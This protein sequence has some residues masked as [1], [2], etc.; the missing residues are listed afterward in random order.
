MFRI[1]KLSLHNFKG[2]K[3][4]EISFDRPRTI[5]GGPNGYGK[6]SIFDALELLFTGSIK[7]ML[8]YKSG[9]D[10]RTTLKENYKPLVFDTS[11]DEITVE[12]IL[13][14]DDGNELRV[15]RWAE[16]SRM[17][18]PVDF[19][20]FS[21]LQYY[22]Q[23]TGT[24]EDVDT[25]VDLT[26]IFTPL[27]EQYNFLNYLTQEE[28]N[29]FL[30]C[31]ESERKQKINSLFNTTEF[32]VS[33]ERLLLVRNEVL[34]RA[35][36]LSDE[37]TKVEKDIEG[38]KSMA[39]QTNQGESDGTGHTK[40]F[41]KEIE[42]DELEPH[43]SFET[44]NNILG[45]NG[46]L[47]QL[48][49]YCQNAAIYELYETYNKLDTIQ[50]ADN[51]RRL[52]LWLEWRKKEELLTRFDKYENELRNKWEGLTLASIHLFSLDVPSY[53]PEGLINQ[54]DVENL[55]EQLSSIK[56]YA[57]S[58]GNLQKAYSDL[59][60]ARKI[61]ERTLLDVE[62]ELKLTKCPL[63]GT[64]HNSESELVK[65]ITDFGIQFNDSL[66][67]ITQGVATSVEQVKAQIEKIIIKPIDEFFRSSGISRELFDSYM[68][69]DRNSL[70]E[71]YSFLIRRL[72]ISG[73]SLEDEQLLV[74]HIKKWENENPLVLP[75]KLDV[76]LLR[77]VYS[78]YG[79]YLLP[80]MANGAAI[81]KKR[82]YLTNLWNETTSKYLAEKNSLVTAL[83]AQYAKLN[84]RASLIKQTMD[85]IKIQ[86]SS[87]LSRMVSQIETLFYIYTGRIMQ[88]NYYGRGCYLK[89]N[90]ANSNVLFTSGSPENEVDALFKMSSGQLVS[91]SVAF[92][93]TVN[94]LYANHH[95]IAIDDPVQTIDDL[96]LWGLMETLRHDFIDSTILLSTHERDFGLLL[97]DK[98]NKMGLPTEY[99]DMSQHHK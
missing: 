89:Y 33:V 59:A 34:T 3:E 37:I 51:M 4:T 29:C 93:L 24:F 30:K 74:T 64:E 38:L 95:I 7:R 66:N 94:K 79:R 16:Q 63:C 20:A 49:Y 73:D 52:V 77:R 91:I 80:E 68:A 90:S 97:T 87:Y 85:K 21:N 92:M 84:G 88:D 39:Y 18:N 96:N 12:A 10:S 69:L 70:G 26:G 54:E 60:G 11:I 23:T 1:V 81:E 32:D 56:I 62:D 35:R 9:H 99:V 67:Q 98:F 53:L 46:L 47:D 50:E 8:D 17:R 22:N 42:W 19:S 75:E 76:A 40:L 36:G 13:L 83:R 2:F 48:N 58:A 14:V 61:A 82:Q 15:R 65:R 25:N 55:N 78:S 57:T 72:S 45:E 44:F 43:I 6:T 27:R 28:A 71:Q 5:L 31:K 86:R 41:N